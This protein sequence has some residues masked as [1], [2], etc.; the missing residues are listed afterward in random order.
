MNIFTS[1]ILFLCIC[2]KILSGNTFEALLFY[3]I[4]W[5]FS[6]Y[7]ILPLLSLTLIVWII[8]KEKTLD[9]VYCE[10]THY[11]RSSSRIHINHLYVFFHPPWI[12]TMTSDP[13]AIFYV[14][15]KQ[16]IGLRL[17]KNTFLN[18]QDIDGHIWDKKQNPF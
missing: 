3:S 16:N 8:K 13:K 18:W 6:W 2:K 1:E 5:F 11:A 4:E 17:A 10:K 15:V 12:T 7:Q 9:W 14:Y